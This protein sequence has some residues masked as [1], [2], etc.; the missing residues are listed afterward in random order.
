MKSVEENNILSSEHHRKEIEKIMT[1]IDCPKKFECYESGFEN[2]CKVKFVGAESVIEC[3]G[4]ERGTC[5][6][7]LAFGYSYFWCFFS[8]PPE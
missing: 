5:I 4:S 6:F 7:S 8:A 1:D 2:L 3:L